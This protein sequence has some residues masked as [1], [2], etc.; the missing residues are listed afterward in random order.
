MHAHDWLPGDLIVVLESSLISR[1]N[2]EAEQFTRGLQL[3]LVVQRSHQWVEP[4][5]LQE[6]SHMF[7][8]VFFGSIVRKKPLDNEL[9]SAT[10]MPGF[11]RVPGNRIIHPDEVHNPARLFGS[12][13]VTE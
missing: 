8:V 11:Y 2:S 5:P 13:R 6:E 7:Y 12:H 9:N 4:N 1:L 10:V 3:G